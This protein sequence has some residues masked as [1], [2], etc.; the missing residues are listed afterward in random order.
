[1]SDARICRRAKFREKFVW[2][3]NSTIVSTDKEERIYG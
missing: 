3:L 1:M 2:E